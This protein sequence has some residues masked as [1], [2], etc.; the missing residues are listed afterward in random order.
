[1][2]VMKDPICGMDVDPV[3]AK[4]RGLITTKNGEKYY[5]CNQSCKDKFEW[6]KGKGDKSE[7]WY[8]SQA[9]GNLFPWFLGIVLIVGFISAIYLDFM[10]LY[11][12][13]FF[14]IFSLM[15]MPDW[16]GFVTAF[17]Q[18]DLIA[19]NVK[20]YGWIYPAIEFGLGILYLTE[21]FIPFAAWVTVFVLGIG[22][23]GVGKNMLSKNKVQCACLG[24]KIKVPLTKV[25]LLENLL[26]V[27]MA[28]MLI[29][30]FS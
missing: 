7:P 15:K 12:G 27:I 19:K 24:T 17:S 5:F 28:I 25:T 30:G 2:A 14:I 8:R 29:S 6:G 1:M 22:A 10:L 11:M 16:K 4:K 3:V 18:Y 20:F 13:I 26:M 9:F 21:T 23:V